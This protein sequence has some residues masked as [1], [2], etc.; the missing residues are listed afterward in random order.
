MSL[1]RAY[2]SIEPVPVY[3]KYVSESRLLTIDFSDMLAV[4]ETVL[5]PGG[6]ISASVLVGNDATPQSILSG[7][8]TVISPDVEQMIT[9]G[10]AGTQYMVS[11]TITT[12]SGEV[13]TGKVSFWIVAG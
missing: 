9:G 10:V 12:S 13:L 4:G 2:T 7:S 8:P 11:A 6:S 1:A 3:P 5:S